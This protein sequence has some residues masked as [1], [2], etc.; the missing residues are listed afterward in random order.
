V[1]GLVNCAGIA[2][3]GTIDSLSEKDIKS[4]TDVNIN[5]YF[6]NA[7]IA[8][9]KMIKTSSNGTIVNISSAAARGASKDSSL[10][11]VT[12]DAQCMMTRSWALD[13]GEKGIRVNA[14]LCGDLYGDEE[15]GI[16]SEIWSQKY[17]EQKAI[18][19]KLVKAS[20]PRLGQ[21]T[22]NKEIRALVIKYYINRTALAK[23]V[24]YKD[25]VTMVILLSSEL[26]SKITGESIAV[27]S[28]Q[29]TAFSR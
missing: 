4:V 26:T 1:S 28:G 20:D 21:K 14:I 22:L 19:K 9:K 15:K 11:G 7:S 2:K 24:T 16:L 23:E 13:L 3:L 12:K 17:F 5:G 6:L 25:A 10:Y 18:D 29:P 8:S 27:T